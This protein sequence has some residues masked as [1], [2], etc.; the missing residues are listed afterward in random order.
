MMSFC[1]PKLGEGGGESGVVCICEGQ[2]HNRNTGGGRLVEG[3]NFSRGLIGNK[4]SN[5]SPQVFKDYDQI[6]F[7]TLAEKDPFFII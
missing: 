3:P 5:I 1:S 7:P 2:K 4:K 6:F